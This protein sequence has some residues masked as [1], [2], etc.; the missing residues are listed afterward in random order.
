MGSIAVGAGDGEDAGGGV[1]SV[2]VVVGGDQEIGEA[3]FRNM[4]MA[5]VECSHRHCFALVKAA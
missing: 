4:L 2:E 3:R 5:L 1:D